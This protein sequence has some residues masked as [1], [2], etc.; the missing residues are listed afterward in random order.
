MSYYSRQQNR[1]RSEATE[2]ER[3]ISWAQWQYNKYPELKL[4]YH[5]PNGGSRNTLEAA[6]LKRQGVKAGVPD[7]CLPVARQN[8]HGLYIE[9]KWGKNKVTE[10]QSQWLDDLREQGYNAIVCY[11]ADEAIRAIEDY[12]DKWKDMPCPYE[13]NGKK[14]YMQCRIYDGCTECKKAWVKGLEENEDAPENTKSSNES[15]K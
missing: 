1:K 3:L 5:V 13:R 12:L 7:L 9:M 6:N 10:N 4:L 2:Q 11:G 14:Q 15:D 8:F